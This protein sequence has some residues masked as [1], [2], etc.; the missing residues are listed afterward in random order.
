[1]VRFQNARSVSSPAWQARITGRV[2]LPS[3][4]SSPTVLPNAA[5]SAA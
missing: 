1:M 2:T 5:C 3:R 4:K